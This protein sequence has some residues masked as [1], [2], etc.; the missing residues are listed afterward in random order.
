PKRIKL[1][2]TALSQSIFTASMAESR[3]VTKAQLRS[4]VQLQWMPLVHIAGT[5]NSLYALFNGRRIALL[6]RFD[7]DKWHELL[8]RHRP[9]FANFPPSALRMV[10]ERNFPKEDFS[11]L[12]AI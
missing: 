12:I 11:S 7:V 10:M 9:R 2:R 4:S 3:D 8:V 6:E 1:A 5:W